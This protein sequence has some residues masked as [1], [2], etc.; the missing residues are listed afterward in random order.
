VHVE[1]EDRPGVLAQ[2]AEQLAAHGVSVAR[3]A[4]R[5]LAHGAA[6][7]IVTHEAPSGNVDDALG[8]I[9]DLDEV[10]A[11]PDRFRVI[12]ERGV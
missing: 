10:R 11:P 2:L 9:A 3:L 8:A 1:V 7:D 12:T 6:L 5:Q 4:Q